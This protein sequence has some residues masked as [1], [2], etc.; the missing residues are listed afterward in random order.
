MANMQWWG[1]SRNVVG[2]HCTTIYEGCMHFQADHDS[3]DKD[4]KKY[5]FTFSFFFSL[6]KFLFCLILNNVKLS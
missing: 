4:L 6:F 1:A 3:L 2:N 5:I